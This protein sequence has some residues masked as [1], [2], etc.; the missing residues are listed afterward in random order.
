VP[1]GFGYTCP[2]C[3][4]V[5]LIAPAAAAPSAD[6]ATTNAASTEPQGA[7][8]AEAP[9]ATPTPAPPSSRPSAAARSDLVE[10]PKCAQKQPPGDTA[11]HRCGLKFAYVAT[12]RAVLPGDPLSGNPSATLL[13]ARWAALEADLDDEE[14]HRAFIALC[15]EVQA[16]EFAGHCYRRLGDRDGEDERVAGY[17]HRVIQAALLRAGRL[18]ERANNFAK[19]RLRSLFALLFGALVLLGFAVGYY[20]LTRY[21]VFWQHN[22]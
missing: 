6:S 20:L 5:N 17:R 9:A 22:G 11:C 21:Q 13:T 10:C 19:G 14:G 12:G 16:L 4:H 8:L 2:H 3:G 1:G 18:D 7:P 15:G